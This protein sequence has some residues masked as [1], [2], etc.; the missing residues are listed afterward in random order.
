MDT[1]HKNMTLFSLYLKERQGLDVLES[2]NG[3]VTYKF[4]NPDCYIQDIYVLPEKR[5][6]GVAAS[7]ADQVAELAKSKGY[8]I[9]TGSVDC[10][11]NGA[12]SSEKILLAYGMKPYVTEGNLTY[13][14]KEI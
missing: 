1:K 10:R 7:M 13:F 3:F 8:R 12:E 2:E 6:E 11:A 14:L 5:K 9:L 4:R